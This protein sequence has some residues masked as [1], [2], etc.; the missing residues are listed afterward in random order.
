MLAP[1]VPR[2]R[3]LIDS[4]RMSKNPLEVFTQYSDRMGHTFS[5][6]F[7]GLQKTIVT[8]H[9]EV[10]QHILKK[11]YT[12]YH[13]SDIQ[14]RRMG[15][16][17]G[18]GLLTSH[19]EYWLTQR[20][21]IQE[22]FHKDKLVS[23]STIM[24]DVLAEFL[25]R[26]AEM[27]EKEPVDICQLMM[28]L[29]FRIVTKTLFS[30]RLTDD[31]LDLIS[32]SISS[33]QKFIIRQISQ[34]YLNLWFRISGT[35]RKYE[36]LRDESDRVILQNIKTRRKSNE[37]H[38]DMLQTLL[39]ARYKETGQGMTDQQILMESIQLIVA[40][41]ETSS[42]A[43]SWILYL[44]TQH[45]DCF[46]RVREE[47]KNQLGDAPLRYHDLPK[48]KYTTQVIEESLR[49][50][51]PFWLIDRMAVED[52]EI[53]GY[54]IPKNTMII[55]F[56]YGV[57]HSPE[58]WQNPDKFDPD[59]FNEENIKKQK[60]FSHLPFGG[61]PRVCIGENYAML[62]ILTIL[63]TLLRKYDFQLAQNHPVVMGP[64]IILRPKGGIKMKFAK[65][66]QL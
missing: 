34:P 46:A 55:V 29:T 47:I 4:R 33:I 2:L 35:L 14:V 39:S 66:S 9:P 52:D 12:N 19:G 26:K 15:H 59:R 48:L 22:G 49:L 41:H 51:P 10:I 31:E 8:R 17:L 63:A 11:N 40:G 53:M 3:A 61:G 13:K 6:H 43:L 37:H 5:F 56:I 25:E 50:Y 24:D 16:F 21:L 1:Q 7:G 57:H 62:Q 27:M 44:L 65:L 23:I 42:N 32:N 30:T 58:Y 64:M 28:E 60:A 18:S 20:R 36:A 45:P 38:A 54:S